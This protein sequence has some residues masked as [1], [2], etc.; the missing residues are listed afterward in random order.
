MLANRSMAP[1]T[2]I[3]VLSYPDVREAAKWLCVAFGFVERLR[4]ADHRVQLRLGDASVIISLGLPR[5]GEVRN[6]M[7]A[8]QSITVRID[9]VEDHCVRA[10]A[11]GA[12]ILHEPQIFPYG[13][14]QYS[15]E[16]LGGHIWV[17]S[18]SLADVDPADWGGEL[19]GP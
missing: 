5:D 12:V 16:D 17:F 11:A 1:G 3:P 9:D 8:T 4:V 15:A 7:Q 13:E 14:K 18:Q 10:K 6:A 19:V 2:I